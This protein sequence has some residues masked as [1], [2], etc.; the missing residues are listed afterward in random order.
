[1]HLYGLPARMDEICVIAERH[2]LFLLEDCA[3]A[4][5]AVY[6]G[7]QVGTIGHAASYSFFPGRTSARGETQAGWSRTTRSSPAQPG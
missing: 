3:Q 5:G 6:R 4:H 7:R 1:V 2:S